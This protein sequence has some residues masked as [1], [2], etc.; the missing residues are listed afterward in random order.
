MFITYCV[1]WADQTKVSVKVGGLVTVKVGV[2]PPLL[3]GL[4]GNFLSA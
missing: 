1:M 2:H 3:D 4:L